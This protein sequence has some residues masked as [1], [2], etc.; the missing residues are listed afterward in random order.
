MRVKYIVKEE[1]GHWY[2][3]YSRRK[4]LIGWGH[5]E[6]VCLE[7]KSNFLSDTEIRDWAERKIRQTFGSP[8][9]VLEGEI[10]V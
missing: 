7:N 2:Y 4:G 1:S 8:Q 5:T 9:I 6:Y 10:E 3:L